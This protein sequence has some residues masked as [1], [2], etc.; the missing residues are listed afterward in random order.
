[1]TVSHLVS[2]PGASITFCLS[3]DTKPTAGMTSGHILLESDTGRVFK[4]VTDAWVEATAGG[5]PAWGEVTGTL[6]DQT[7]LQSALNAKA[8]ALGLDDNYVTDAE[9]TKLSNLSGTNTGDQTLPVKATGA[10]ADTGTDDAKFLT[11]KAIE[12]SAYVKAT[13]VTTQITGT[14]ID[15]LTQGDDNTDLNASTSRHGL[16][17]KLPGGTTNFFREDGTF[18]APTAQAA[19]LDNPGTGALSVATGKYHLS[20]VRHQCTTTQRITV[21]GT[22]RL[23]ILN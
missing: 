11:P 1:M 16:L 19:D 4:W 13:A 18:A 21:A 12:D 23:R 17:P 2:R 20:G 8:P 3:S 6:A 9:K 7:D 15:D 5:S 10:E 22:G 14:K